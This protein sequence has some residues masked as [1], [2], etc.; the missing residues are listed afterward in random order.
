M[1]GLGTGLLVQLCESGG[2][3]IFLFIIQI[4]VPIIVLFLLFLI[5]ALGA[6]D[7]KLFSVIGGIWNIKLLSYCVIF[8]FLSGAV[9][10]F[11]KLIY[12]RNLL[13]SLIY[14]FQYVET[15]I[16]EGKIRMYHKKSHKNQ[17]VMCFSI[18]IFIGFCIAMEVVM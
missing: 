13:K 8:S 11:F 14:F 6:G 5:G 10:A 7:I 18:A 1:L 9:Y 3:G 12:Q 16:R 15:S 2:R 17:N 4:I